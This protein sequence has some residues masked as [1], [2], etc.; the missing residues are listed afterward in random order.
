MNHTVADIIRRMLVTLGQGT[1]PSANGSWPIYAHN[2]PDTPDNA[3]VVYDTA[4]LLDGRS[5]ADSVMEEHYGI[6]IMVRSSG[7]TGYTKADA[8]AVAM[9]TVQNVSVTV[10]TTSYVVHAITR[11]SGVLKAGTETPTSKRYL[12]TVNAVVA[13]T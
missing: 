5:G 3:V 7:V 9:D 1:L 2:L 4:G 12:F 8:I 13:L 11:K 6:E 10:D